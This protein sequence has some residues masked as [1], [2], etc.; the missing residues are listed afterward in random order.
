M[1]QHLV[2]SESVHVYELGIGTAM[3]CHLPLLFACV[4][5][6]EQVGNAIVRAAV[7]PVAWQLLKVTADSAGGRIVIVP[8]VGESPTSKRPTFKI[9]PAS[10]LG[11]RARKN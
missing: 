1:T 8:L 11:T 5:V 9:R 7:D 4:T 6:K 10:P 3:F 2:R